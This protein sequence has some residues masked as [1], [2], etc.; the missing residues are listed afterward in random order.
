MFV[1]DFSG[2]GDTE[3]HEDEEIWSLPVGTSLRG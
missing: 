3:A 2:D 1:A